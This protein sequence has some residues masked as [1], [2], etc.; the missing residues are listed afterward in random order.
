MIKIPYNE[1]KEYP[2]ATSASYTIRVIGFYVWMFLSLFFFLGIISLDLKWIVSLLPIIAIHWWIQSKHDAIIAF[3]IKRSIPESKRWKNVSEEELKI[4]KAKQRKAKYF[5]S[6][7]VF[8]KEF[9]DEAE[10]MGMTAKEYKKYCKE[11][12]TMYD[13]LYRNYNE[14]H[15]PPAEY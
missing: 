14:T 9:L 12:I 13:E 4:A 7:G 15:Y 10:K 1:Y 6:L 3:I 5:L 2:G 11:I 8:R